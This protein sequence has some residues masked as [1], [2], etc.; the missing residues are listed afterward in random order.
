MTAMSRDPAPPTE[1]TPAS[2]AAPAQGGI[3]LRGLAKGLIMIGSLVAVGVAAKQVGLADMLDTKWLDQKV[4]GQ[5]LSGE[6]IFIALGA[7]LSAIGLP[8]QLVAFGGGYAFGLVGG[9]AIALVA[10]TLGC[11]LAFFYARLLGRS[12]VRDRFGKRIRRIDDFLRGHPFTMTLLI[13]FLPVGSNVVT[14]LAAGVSSVP[15]P[16]FLSG[17]AAGYLP[18]TVIFALL[19]TGI[20]LDTA[21]RTGVSIALFVASSLIGVA[22]YRRVR[23]ARRVVSDD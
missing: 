19:G 14:N 20:H 15:A 3:G 7:V 1:D 23:G 11:A 9:T 22:L 18:Q 13:R 17:S 8:R 2:G 10:Q 12:A 6:L 21:Y 5:G 16:A 4:I